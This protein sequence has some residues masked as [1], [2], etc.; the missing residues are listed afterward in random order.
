MAFALNFPAID[1]VLIE[2]GP[3]VIRW[4]ALAYL[5]GLLLGWRMM[6][7]IVRKADGTVTVPHVDDFLVWAT[8]G[9]ILGGRLGYAIFYKPG[10]YVEEPLALL[11]VW[12]GGMSFH[13]GILGVIVAAW[14]FSRRNAL[15]ILTFG[16]MIARVAPI[17]LF[18]GRIANFINGE[19]FGRVSDV[20]WAMAFPMGGPE[21]RHPSQL[22]EAVLEGFVLFCVL[23]LMARSAWVRAR[24]GVLVGAF[25]V[26]YGLARSS[27][28]F[29]R[30]PDAHLGLIGGFITMGQILSIPMIVAGAV[31]IAHARKHAGPS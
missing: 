3:V 10:V 6:V 13:G 22:Y 21:P 27:A 16:D 28:E 8:F 15:P 5:A 12:Q 25:L 23:N 26:G 7:A 31:V 4:Y 20:P 1:P 29:F 24:P 9:V 19:L 11:A 30:Q 18:F 2:I 17:G 14:W